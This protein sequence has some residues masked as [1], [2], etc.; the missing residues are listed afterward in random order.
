MLFA[1]PSH[2]HHWT[3]SQPLAW[4]DIT[5]RVWRALDIHKPVPSD[6]DPILKKSRRFRL[7]HVSGDNPPGNLRWRCLGT[8]SATPRAF[9]STSHI[10]LIRRSPHE[11]A[12]SDVAVFELSIENVIFGGFSLGNRLGRRRRQP[13]EGRSQRMCE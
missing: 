9:V 7:F 2:V 4:P 13:E 5:I 1:N 10:V 3:H 12:D 8:A 6:L 11:R